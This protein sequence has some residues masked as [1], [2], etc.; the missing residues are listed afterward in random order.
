V[1]DLP[2]FQRLDRVGEDVEAFSTTSLPMKPITGSPLA[3]PMLLRQA[4]SRRSGLKIS[5]SMPR[6]HIPTL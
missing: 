5:R 4:E 2:S 3:M 1:P 6:L